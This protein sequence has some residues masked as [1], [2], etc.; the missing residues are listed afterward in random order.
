MAQITI[1]FHILENKGVTHRY[2]KN[3]EYEMKLGRF[4][5]LEFISILMVKALLQWN[6]LESADSG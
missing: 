1:Q 5:S 4:F 6:V 2:Y 3:Q